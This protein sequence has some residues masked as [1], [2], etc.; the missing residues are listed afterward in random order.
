MAYDHGA[1][2]F[3]VVTESP[4]SGNGTAW[5]WAKAYGGS[6]GGGFDSTGGSSTA[7][8][9]SGGSAY[10]QRAW[11]V[12]HWVIALATAIFHSSTSRIGGA[13]DVPAANAAD[14]RSAATTSAPHPSAAPSA[15]RLHSPAKRP[16]YDPPCRGPCRRVQCLSVERRTGAVPA[17]R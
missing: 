2:A 3:V 10:R 6:F 8:F 17:C 5:R 7:N 13:N 9:K 12:G 1:I 11:W 4:P 14:A 15:G 16:P